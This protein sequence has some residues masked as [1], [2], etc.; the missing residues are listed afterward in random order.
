MKLTGI[1]HSSIVVTDLERASRFYRDVL[2]LRPIASPSNFTHRVAWFELGDQHVHLMQ[3]QEPDTI[4]P[5]HFALHVDDARAAREHFRRHGVEVQET[6]PIA[7]ADRFVV[8]DPDG[9][10]IE[11]IEWHR[12]W[13]PDG[14][15]EREPTTSMP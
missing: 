1:H 10:G 3:R 13:Q 5:R 4:S 6:V 9:N 12:P 7:G 2:G 15:S 14:S 8:Q 11:V